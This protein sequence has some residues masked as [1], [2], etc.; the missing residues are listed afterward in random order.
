MPPC[1]CV[2]IVL[3]LSACEDTGR[4]LLYMAW[5]RTNIGVSMP[6]SMSR[7]SFL[8]AFARSTAALMVAG[9]VGAGYSYYVEPSW[10]SIDQ[11]DVPIRGLPD[12]LYGLKIAHLSD[13]HVS[14][15]VNPKAIAQAVEITNRQQ[16]DLIVLTGD[17]VTNGTEY[18]RVAARTI[19]QLRAPLGVYATLGN[20][21]HWTNVPERIEAEFADAGITP[22]L[23]RNV[24]IPV[25]NSTFWLAGVDD[26]WEEK[27]DLS[28]ALHGI[29]E[30][31]ITFLLAHE[32]DFADTAGRRNIALQF[33]GHSHGGQVRL[34]LFGPPILPW[35]GRRYPIGLQRVRDSTMQVYTSRG[36]GVVWP[37]VRLNCRPEVA[38]LRLVPA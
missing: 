37:E 23:N 35:L 21:D 33:S 17:F 22:L 16:P 12:A 9:S 30:D 5:N 2:R 38:I 14:P 15:V 8:K 28:A 18:I 13:L 32:P 24:R 20:H 6:P 19:S 26:I 11:T 31:A 29:P 10:L 4:S 36:I 7:R 34:P 1:C 25:P 27:A 3:H